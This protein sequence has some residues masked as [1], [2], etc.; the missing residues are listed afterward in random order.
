[1]GSIESARTRT[2]GGGE[3]YLA[4][5]KP[6]MT[7]PEKHRR[8]IRAGTPNETPQSPDGPPLCAAV[9]AYNPDAGFTSRLARVLAEVPRCLIVDNS[10]CPLGQGPAVE[11]AR[12]V[13]ADYIPNASNRGV[14]ASI[15]QSLAWA[16]DQGMAWLLLLDQDTQLTD[17]GL[18]GPYRAALDAAGDDL[19]GIGLAKPHYARDPRPGAVET[20]QILTSGSLLRVETVAAAGGA[21][22]E[23][24]V[25]GVDTELCLRLRARGL[26]LLAIHHPGLEHRIGTGRAVRV[27]GRT[28]YVTDHP[29]V[30]R[31]YGARNRIL[32]A[33]RHRLP[34]DWYL[35]LREDFVAPL[36]E[37]RSFAKLRASVLGLWHGVRGRSGPAPPRLLPRS[38]GEPC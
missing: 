17:A 3:I 4:G 8:G 15:N 30:R 20:E 12:A 23:L 1:M 37:R 14:A 13:G 32:I 21:W 2:V 24:F 28:L 36:F 31:Y 19:A 7:G 38:S 33:R 25:D 16:R 35:S 18:L 6:R 22:E 29:P 27:A 9:L 11:A 5:H 26:R 10:E 34:F